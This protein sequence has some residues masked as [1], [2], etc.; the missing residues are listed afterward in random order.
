MISET[1]RFQGR[2]RDG[3]TAAERR[4]D[5]ERDGED[6]VITGEGKVLRVTLAAVLADP[7]L[8][9]VPR[10]LALPDGARIETGDHDAVALLFPPKSRIDAAA[11]WLESRWA[12]ALATIPVIAG[13]TW[14]FVAI[15]LPLGAG[16]VAQMISPRIE[17]AI[18]RQSLAALDRVALNPS[19]L[20]PDTQE[21]IERRF[22]QFVAGE[23]GEENYE[24]VFR[25]GA[26]GPNALALP[27]GIIIVTDDMV[28][29]APNEDELLAVLA[30]EIGHVQG[31]HAL[32]MILQDSGVIVLIAALAGDAVSMSVL[33]AA[34][35]TA[36]LQS[37]YSRQFEKEA[38]EYAFAHLRRHGYSPQ[39]FADMMRRLQQADRRP[40]GESGVLRYLSTHPLTEER[41]ERAEAQR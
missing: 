4:V 24:L 28:H 9:G 27:G 37:H 34:L 21:K 41:I 5:I 30:H 20:D 3:S 23:P 16:P 29:L 19:T 38:D 33:A 40:A 15:V 36:L 25:G 11:F 1:L 26:L 22:R 2:F 17:S 14:L 32:R 31:R 39:L 10:M 13:L 7:R 18:G 35:P 6:L 8:P 12:A